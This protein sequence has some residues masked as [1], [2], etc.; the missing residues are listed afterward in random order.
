MNGRH[1][2]QKIGCAVAN[3][4]EIGVSG[5]PATLEVGSLRDLAAAQH[6]DPESPLL[7]SGHGN[8]L[9][10]RV[11]TTVDMNPAS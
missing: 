11:S 2:P 1:S 10:P 5:F 3:G 4:V 6:P 8:L 9:P 7:F